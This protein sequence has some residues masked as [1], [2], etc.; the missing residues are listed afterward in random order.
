MTGFMAGYFATQQPVRTNGRIDL[1]VAGDA[2]AAS[3]S[4]PGTI[5][6]PLKTINEAT[7]RINLYTEISDVFIVHVA[8]AP[9]AGYTWTTSLNAHVLRERVIYIN[10]G[11]GQG[12][13]GFTQLLGSTVAQ[14]GS[15]ASQLVAPAGLG[16]NTYRG[17]VVQVLTGAA[18]GDL[19]QIRDHTDTTIIP[20]RN[21]SA[22]IA[23]NDTFRIVSS[24]TAIALS[25]GQPV[26]I[27]VGSGYGAGATQ[28]IETSNPAINPMVEFINFVF[29]PASVT[30]LRFM[31][32]G[33]A[34]FGCEIAVTTTQSVQLIGDDSSLY[35]GTEWL[36]AAAQAPVGSLYFGAPS[37]TSWSGWGVYFPE[38]VFFAANTQGGFFVAGTGASIRGVNLLGQT[39]IW[40][41]GSS[42]VLNTVSSLA[43]AAGGAGSRLVIGSN[44][45]TVAPQVACAN[46]AGTNAA[47]DLEGS[48]NV[49]TV[50]QVFLRR[51]ALSAPVLLR[52]RGPCMV[53][54][55]MSANA[56]GSGSTLGID[57]RAGSKVFL[58]GSTGLVGP[59]GADLS[60][61]SGV[62]TSAAGDIAADES[63][64]NF[65]TQ[66]QIARIA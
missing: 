37:V 28:A 56:S 29:S 66:A 41:G 2:A 55:G 11:A 43:F 21:F 9:I 32:A 64:T 3:D 4:N 61:D 18:A 5:A 20:V 17:K 51:V 45:S 63:L 8:P 13:D 46:T 27:V 47:L 52:T 39:M 25:G 60:V 22:A 1:Y 35:F 48:S 12:G 16:V 44:S 49:A 42:S 62:T 26:N 14:A 24:A 6:L 50:A 10:D 58:L 54:V 34:F 36:G 65:A 19:R 31:S 23:A 57:A 33:V 53:T 38:G 7:R 40:L 30:A 59:G 15:S